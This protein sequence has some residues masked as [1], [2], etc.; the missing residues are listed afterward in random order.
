MAQGIPSETVMSYLFEIANMEKYNLYMQ[1]DEEMP[2]ALYAQFQAGLKRILNHEPLAHILG[3]SWFYGYKFKVNEDVLIPRYETEELV[4]QILARKDQYFKDQQVTAIDVGTG[5]GAI[6]ISL[7]K[8][9][10]SMD[11]YASDIS[12][13]AIAVA[14]HNA[15]ANEAKV[16]FMVGDMLQPF[17][18]QNMQVDIL[19]SN[20]PYIPNDEKL[21]TEVVDHEPHVALFGGSDGLDFYRT[22]LKNCHKLLKPRS[23]MAFEIGY[24]QFLALEQEIQKYCPDATY[25]I[26]KDINGKDRMLFV[27][28]NLA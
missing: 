21:E 24:N 15:Q 5:S 17:I 26:L 7:K 1:F 23:F 4:A 13:A 9:E 25:E 2:A 16:N 6:A 11:M 20:P 22:I 27:Y 19:V 10:D 28:F 18:A 14:K 8:E 12:E 3:Y